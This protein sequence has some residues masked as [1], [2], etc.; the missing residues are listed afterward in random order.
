MNICL[1]FYGRPKNIQNLK[2]VYDKY[3]YNEKYNYHIVYTTWKTENIDKFRSFF[4]NA[5]INQ[6][7]CPDETNELYKNI[8][9]NYNVDPTNLANGRNIKGFFLGMYSKDYS[10]HTIVEYEEQNNIKFDI[11]VSLRPDI[12]LDKNVS[13]YF[14]KFVNNTI[15]VGS[16]PCYDIYNQGA[17]P[18]QFDMANR[19]DML[20]LLDFITI[21]NTC[22]VDGTNFFHGETSGY[23]ILK[24]KNLQIFYL[25][26]YAFVYQ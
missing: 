5:Y 9:T 7:D 1:N 11:I 13:V 6:I 16:D 18:H 20:Q 21:L 23:K 25:D 14:D 3:L 2:D 26:F 24:R 17:Y 22:T 19:N 4:P 12:K 15:F 8:T 10:R